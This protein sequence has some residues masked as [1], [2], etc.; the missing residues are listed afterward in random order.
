MSMT[1]ADIFYSNKCEEIHDKLYGLAQ[2][3]LSNSF[4]KMMEEAKDEEI[5][6]LY[7]RVKELEDVMNF[8][9]DIRNQNLKLSD[10]SSFEALQELFEIIIAKATR[11]L[12]K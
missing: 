8:Y 4:N 2:P 9:V 3:F 12:D 1:Y 11:V 10:Y 6:R 5:N 7:D